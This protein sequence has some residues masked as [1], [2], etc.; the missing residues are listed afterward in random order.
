MEAKAEADSGRVVGRMPPRASV[1]R[2]GQ[3]RQGNS[4]GN[5]MQKGPEADSAWSVQRA[6]QGLVLG[7]VRWAALEREAG[8]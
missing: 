7:Q 1:Q 4:T 3:G 8:M 2:A 5:S 6:G